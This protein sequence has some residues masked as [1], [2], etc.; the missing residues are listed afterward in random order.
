MLSCQSDSLNVSESLWSLAHFW[1]TSVNMPGCMLLYASVV[2]QLWC[3]ERESRLR[4]SLLRGLGLLPRAKMYQNNSIIQNMPLAANHTCQYVSCMKLNR[5]NAYQKTH[6]LKYCSQL[7]PLWFFQQHSKGTTGPQRVEW[8]NFCL[9]A[10]KN[11]G[12][13]TSKTRCWIQN[14]TK[15]VQKVI[16][17][18]QKHGKTCNEKQ[19]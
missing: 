16:Q 13:E 4:L 3:L 15:M 9:P 17:R 12:I 8:I 10:N 14:D 19:L 11:E 7:H 2:A 5:G 6:Q 18:L 1:H